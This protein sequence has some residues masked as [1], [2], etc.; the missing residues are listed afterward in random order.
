MANSKSIAVPKC[1]KEIIVNCCFHNIGCLVNLF[2][3]G[4]NYEL[5][6]QQSVK[7]PAHHLQDEKVGMENTSPLQIQAKKKS[8]F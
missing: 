4:E 5:E 8:K 7:L 2:Q 1:K 3:V 6:I